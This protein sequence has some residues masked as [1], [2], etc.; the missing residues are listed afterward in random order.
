M[1]LK[2]IK[3]FVKHNINKPIV[4]DFLQSQQKRIELLEEENKDL[5]EITEVCC[6]PSQR[7]LLRLEKEHTELKERNKELESGCFFVMER[8]G[9]DVEQLSISFETLEEAEKFKNS[10]YHKK[11][12]PYAFIVKELLNKTK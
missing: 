6:E 9:E 5:K 8:K 11:H 1:E 2:E 10:D 4:L 12:S 3:G 7:E